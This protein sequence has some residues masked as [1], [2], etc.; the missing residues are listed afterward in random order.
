[1]KQPVFLGSQHFQVSWPIVRLVVV[2]VMNMF[3]SS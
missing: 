2:A 1:M 3:I